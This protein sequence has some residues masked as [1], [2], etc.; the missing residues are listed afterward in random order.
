MRLIGAEVLK[1]VRRRGLMA[2][3]F[4]LTVGSVLLTEIILVVLHAVNPD[5]HGPA[6]GGNN[7]ENTMF[8]AS[9][10]GT[11]AA[12]LIG[13]T[14]GTQDVSN[15]VF[16][17]LVVTGRKRSTLFNVRV[18]GALA[19]FLPILALAAGLAIACSF[20]LAGSLPS[21]TGSNV[22]K[23]VEYSFAIT[24]V[25]VIIAVGL[26]AFASSRVVVGVL[27][28]WNAIVSHLLLQISS[29]G[30]VRKFID[31][32]AAEHFLPRT[33]GDTRIAMSSLAAGLILLGWAAVFSGA[34]RW[35]TTRR[36]A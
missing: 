24:A 34:G 1:L 35:W 28:A 9:G 17:D 29:L 6:G 19:V 36:D 32:A 10:L 23:Y 8:L 27:I 21:P 4:L 14:A 3:T 12:I 7:L 5:H 30:S 33:N 13:A 20:L 15:G 2:W 18:P 22:A 25:N 16:R 11:V 26:A 31:V